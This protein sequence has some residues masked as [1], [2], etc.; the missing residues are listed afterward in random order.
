MFSAG[1]LART[2][3][4][5]AIPHLVSLLDHED[6]NVAQQVI[7]SL[8]QMR[9]A[10]AVDALVKVL[11]RDP[12]LRFAAVHALGE[13][14][15][16]RA[17]SALA[18]LARGRRRAGRRSSAPW[19]RSDRRRRS[20]SCSGWSARTRTP[21]RS[22]SACGRSAR[23]W[24]SS[25]TRRPSRTSLTG[26]S[27]RPPRRRPSGA[28]RA[29]AGLRGARR[30]AAAKGRTPGKSAAMIVKALKLRPLYTA[31]VLAGRDPT[32]REVLEFS[33]VSIGEEIVPVL[34]DGLDVAQRRR[35]ACSPAS[36]SARS[37]TS[38]PR[39]SIEALIGDPN[40]RGARGGDQRARAPRPRRRHPGDGEVPSRSRARSFARRRPRRSAAWTST[41]SR[42]ALLA[43]VE[44]SSFPR[45]HRPDDR[46]REPPRRAPDFI[47]A[48]PVATRP[49]RFAARR[50]RRWRA[51]RPST[52]SERS[53][54]CCAIPTPTSAARS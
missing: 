32:L 30:R 50:S 39:R 47:V 43:L 22:P 16:Q 12:W 51:S 7:D 37:A 2:G 15:D 38:R 18:P 41:R 11:D 4:P 8:A 25:R 36:A 33:A 17:V 9:S 5:A 26:R 53:S 31:L 46:P 20:P 45:A 42:E 23:R 6:I 54:R 52:W 34:R 24:S 35:C 13:I 27:S 19:G 10:L 21:R 3:S 40:A 14:G 1:V 49:L 28:A 29:G 44:D 48:L